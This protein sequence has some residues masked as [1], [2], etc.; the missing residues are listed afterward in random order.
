MNEVVPTIPPIT[1]GGGLGLGQFGPDI[2]A[3]SKIS[4][5]VFGTP[6]TT[7]TEEIGGTTTT[8]QNT[9]SIEAINKAIQDMLE[10]NGS[11]SG[12][13]ALMQGS[14]GTGSY[15]NSS[16]ALLGNDLVAR[17]VGE[18]AK[19]TSGKTTTTSGSTNTTST[20][21]AANKASQAALAAAAIKS[22]LANASKSS[23]G[24][25]KGS[26]KAAGAGAGAP[27]TSKPPATNPAPSPG[28]TPDNDADISG[29]GYAGDSSGD[30][31]ELDN[32]PG[33]E[34]TVTIGD[35]TD[36][37]DYTGNELDSLD[38]LDGGD[39]LDFG[40]TGDFTDWENFDWENF[41]FGDWGD[42][43]GGGLGFGGGM[44]EDF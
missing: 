11:S 15:N 13:A 3:F 14:K 23:Q 5:L 19:L 17:I 20:S 29:T 37:T 16:T 33:P 26:P 2:D 44:F 9:V 18:V 36:I 40:D 39:G 12:L 31:P 41:D 10:G 43:G 27:K 28:N 1:G 25:P 7:K 4:N 8:V 38:G 34:G 42:S 22:M 6:P 21:T 30:N 24:S 35:I 32:G